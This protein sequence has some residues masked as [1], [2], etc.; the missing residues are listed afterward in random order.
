MP[1]YL[2]IHSDFFASPKKSPI[3]VGFGTGI[4]EA[5]SY[6]EKVVIACCD[7]TESTKTD[8]FARKF[9]LRFFEIGVAEQNA[10]GFAAGMAAEGMIP[11]VTSYAVFCPG[12][13]WD[14]VRVSVCYSRMN[15]KIVG[16]HA[17]LS[18][19]PDGATHQALEDIATMRVLPHM[20]VIV[21]ADA[22]EAHRAT[23]ALAQHQGPAYLR[24]ARE[25]TDMIMDESTPFEIGRA[26]V[27]REGSDFT[28]VATGAMVGNA[29]R[30]AQELDRLGID[31]TVV[32]MHTIKPLDREI[33]QKYAKRGVPLMTIEEHQIYGGLG[34]AVAEYLSCFYPL[35]MEIAGV[36]DSFGESGTPQELWDRYGLG[37]DTLTQRARAL[38][39]R[40]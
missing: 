28:L 35:P 2:H 16:S 19:G 37:I 25:A 31:S 7:L 21:P 20:T 24:L 12:R 5:G 4:V 17:G 22:G 30:V 40:R 36:N 32:N 39:S 38:L 1:K 18:V 6:D 23:I 34:G 15:V 26:I 9:P 29:L 8:A 14:Q 11:F 10:V 27:L 3:R 13:A 33:L